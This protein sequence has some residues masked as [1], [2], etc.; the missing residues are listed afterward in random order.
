MIRAKWLRKELALAVCVGVFGV[1]KKILGGRTGKIR[2]F[3]W[4]TI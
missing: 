1:L 3:R 2:D 4:A